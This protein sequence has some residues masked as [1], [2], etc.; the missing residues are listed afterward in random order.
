MYTYAD[1]AFEVASITSCS[2]DENSEYAT[3]YLAREIK[4]TTK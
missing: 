2:N 4:S 1:G 3:K